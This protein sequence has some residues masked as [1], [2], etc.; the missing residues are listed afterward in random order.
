[1]NFLRFP[2]RECIKGTVGSCPEKSLPDGVVSNSP[3][4]ILYLSE[5]DPVYWR[6]D[7]YFCLGH[8]TAAKN[9]RGNRGQQLWF[10]FLFTKT[11]S[12]LLSL[13]VTDGRYQ[14]GLPWIKKELLVDKKNNALKIKQIL[15]RFNL[16]LFAVWVH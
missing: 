13:W 11:F 8:D 6:Q 7:R 9:A 1:M 2:F 10:S 16:K 12:A 3:R 15:F 14:N 4:R 5:N